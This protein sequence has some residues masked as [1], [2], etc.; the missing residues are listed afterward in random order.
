MFLKDT[1]PGQRIAVWIN[2]TTRITV[3]SPD[4]ESV[5]LPAT[6]MKQDGSITVVGWKAG[7]ECPSNYNGNALTSQ[8]KADGYIMY[9]RYFNYVECEPLTGSAQVATN[10]KRAEKPCGQCHRMNDIG[11]K[12]CWWC[13]LTHP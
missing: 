2:K 13:E 1:Q 5:Q 10:N 3:V 9:L 8:M 12:K 4:A 7:E 11:V 6:V